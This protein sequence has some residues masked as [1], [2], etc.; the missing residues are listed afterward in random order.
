[1]QIE[2]KV[3]VTEEELQQMFNLRIEVF[4]YEQHVPKELELDEYD[5]TAIHVIAKIKDK[6]IGCGR[7]LL[8]GDH[9]QIGRV[10]VKK[11]YRKQGIGKQLM[12]ELIR[13]SKE[14][15]AMSIILHAQLPVVHFYE[16]LNFQKQG[17]IFLDA[18]IKHIEMVFGSYVG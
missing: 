18:G 10:V 6:V 16:S 15:G 17:E 5:K 14:H 9:G 12:Q 2:Y 3:A 11:P 1:M 8:K 4:V 13:I 7:I